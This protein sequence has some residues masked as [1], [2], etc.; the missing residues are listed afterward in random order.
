MKPGDR[1]HVD[2]SER[3]TQG[4]LCWPPAYTATLI[5]QDGGG[6]FWLAKRDDGYTVWIDERLDDVRLEEN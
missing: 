6:H 5:A 1:V 3:V 4:A 2:P